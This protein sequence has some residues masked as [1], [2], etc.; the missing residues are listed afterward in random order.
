LTLHLDD[1][2]LLSNAFAL[3]IF[4]SGV[5]YF[6]GPG[7]SA[8]LVLLSGGLGNYLN[9]LFYQTDHL[10]VGAS[11][12]VFG[13]VGLM[14]VLSAKNRVSLQSLRNHFLVPVIAALGIFA[15]LGTN[16]STDVFAH[17]FGLISG[18]AVGLIFG[19]LT[20]TKSARRPDVQSLAMIAF[21]VVI[22]ASWKVQL[23]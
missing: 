11:T 23:G 20:Q 12:A 8:L 16:P 13:A 10:A 17:L 2:H 14:G 1:P 18:I 19:R 5:N 15:L 3:M 9:A 21:C 4:L 6:A 22:W 7:I